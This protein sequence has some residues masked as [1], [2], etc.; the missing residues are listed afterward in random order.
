MHLPDYIKFHWLSIRKAK[1]I[2]RTAIAIA[3]MMIAIEFRAFLFL[4]KSCFSTLYF[5]G[6]FRLANWLGSGVALGTGG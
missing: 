1:P 3:E 4:R 2:S 6:S 5:S